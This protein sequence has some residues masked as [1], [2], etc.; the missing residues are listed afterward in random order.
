[1]IILNSIKKE[2]SMKEKDKDNELNLDS[3]FNNLE[4]EP[5][6]KSVEEIEFEKYSKLFEE[7]FGEKACIAEPSG[8]YEQTINAIKNA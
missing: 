1:M 2:N 5:I 8:T 3:L 6:E 7:R 4:D